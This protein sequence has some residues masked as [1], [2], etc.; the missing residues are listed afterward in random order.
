MKTHPV[1]LAINSAAPYKKV[2]ELI[3]F[4]Y[5]NVSDNIAYHFSYLE[6]LYQ[7]M[8]EI[9]LQDYRV[10][11][12][13]RIKTIIG[14]IASC[15][16]VL[17]YDAIVSLFVTD[18]WGRKQPMCLDPK[19]GFTVLLRYAL[20]FGI[21]NRSLHGRIHRLFELRHKIHLTRGARDPYEFDDAALKDSE[22]TFEDLLRH[23]VAHRQ[24]KIR[25]RQRVSERDILLPWKRIKVLQKR[26]TQRPRTP[27][28]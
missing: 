5:A 11:H 15:A 14:E 21:I 20:D 27:G 18:R 9:R 23:F 3:V 12:G 13:L 19:V 2:L 22:K 6:Y 25:S 1:R 7:L 10:L 24:R 17:L 4:D 28:S 26:C 16:E 8:Q